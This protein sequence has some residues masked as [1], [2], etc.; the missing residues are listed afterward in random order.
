MANW[1]IG[2][3]S[4]TKVVELESEWPFHALLPDATDVVQ[5]I[6]W[7][8]PDFIT[9]DGRMKLSIHA[10]VVEAGDRLIVVDTCAG[11][12][13][14]RPGAAAFENMSTSFLDDFRAAGFD[15]ER[16]DTV[17]CTHLHV[18]HVGWNTRLVD[19]EWVPTFPNATYLFV[20]TEFNHWR[21]EPQHYG[22]VFEDSVKPIVDAGLAQLV[23]SDHLI[24]DGV[25]FEPTPG[26]T[27]GHC[28]VHICSGDEHG[29]IT[30]DMIHHP[31]QIARP[32]ICSSADSD[33]KAAHATRVEALERWNDG[34]LIIGTHWSG[35]TAGRLVADGESLRLS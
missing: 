26:H 23:E 27:P 34:R 5:D 3:I 6:A 21:D 25:C 30:G 18:D 20:E 8:K 28:S 35:R 16:V 14:P 11:N 10:L 19:G 1:Q 12:D 32:E 24:A 15:P 29:I 31:V 22:P 13:K 7:L 2:D 17:V 33:Q 9:D 4:I